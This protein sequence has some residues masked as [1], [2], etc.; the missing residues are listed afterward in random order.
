MTAM[1][2]SNVV[3]KLD[4][5]QNQVEGDE[6]D[7]RCVKEE[8]GPKESNGTIAAQ[9]ELKRPCKSFIGAIF[10]RSRK[11]GR[12][13]NFMMLGPPKKQYMSG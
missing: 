10:H 4:L 6:A 11:T 13:G 12:Q 9:L 8:R 3:Q 5:R 1:L 2:V 7:L